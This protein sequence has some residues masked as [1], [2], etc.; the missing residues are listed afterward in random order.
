[1]S[2][3]LTKRLLILF[4]LFLASTGALSAQQIET[5]HL[6]F[7]QRLASGVEYG[8][9]EGKTISQY[10][11]EERIAILEG[12]ISMLNGL[13]SDTSVLTEIAIVNGKRC[14]T[15][16]YKDSSRV[17][18]I[19]YPANYQL[20]FGTTLME[21]EERLPDAIR[22]TNIPPLEKESIS[23]D[24]LTQQN[25]SIIYVQKGNSYIIPELNSNRYYVAIKR[26]AII[27]TASSILDKKTC[28]D[29]VF[30]ENSNAAADTDFIVDSITPT[31]TVNPSRE[32]CIVAF[33]KKL[34]GCSNPS[35]KE[36]NIL[37]DTILLVEYNNRDSSVSKVPFIP[38]DSLDVSEDSL[39][40]ELLYS[41]NL[42]VESMANLVTGNNIDDSIDINILLV[43]YGYRTEQFI[44]P[45][46][47]WVAF[48]FA[49]GCQPYFGAISQDRDEVV[50]ELIMHNELFGYAHVMKLTFNP[51]IISLN[52][53]VMSAR[54][55]S[56]VP[57]DNLKSLFDEDN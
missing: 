55:N 16:L 39:T 49:E 56:Y 38:V 28:S 25:N 46:R 57:I 14:A 24:V 35:P 42:P 33:F 8:K 17:F 6:N 13:L 50:C 11:F 45:L 53:G 44:V 52:K 34:F 12:D 31:K 21:A 20:I 9:I 27:D 36:N 18:T 37:S 26:G 48:C 23:K 7:L 32:C 41:E 30:V 5:A 2:L 47:Q 40:F 19:S 3:I 15:R 1:M 43:K 54:L 51:E 10:M 22:A 29:S 4:L